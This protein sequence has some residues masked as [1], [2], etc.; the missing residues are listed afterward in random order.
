MEIS[1]VLLILEKDAVVIGL[2]RPV[3]YPYVMVHVRILDNN[4]Y[5]YDLAG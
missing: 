3:Y 4:A 1:L 5:S 2:S